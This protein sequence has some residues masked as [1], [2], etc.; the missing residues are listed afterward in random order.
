MIL[1]F[2]VPWNGSW[3]PLIRVLACTSVCAEVLTLTCIPKVFGH[4]SWLESISG[5][6]L[7]S[8][9]VKPN[10]NEPNPLPDL[11]LKPL[12]SLILGITISVKVDKNCDI[13][14]PFSSILAPIWFP[15]LNF[16]L[17]TSFLEKIGC[18]LHPVIC[19][20]CNAAVMA[21]SLFSLASLT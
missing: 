21:S 4:K 5:K 17:G 11:L 13:G 16:Q 6:N 14:L 19:C 12:Y 18:G 9:E 2:S 8:S 3:N 7:T 15:R 10:D 20:S 1:F